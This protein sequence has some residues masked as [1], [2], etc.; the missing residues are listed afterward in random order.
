MSFLD[1]A[2][3]AAMNALIVIGLIIGGVIIT[4]GLY[5]LWTE[6]KIIGYTFH[7]HPILKSDLEKEND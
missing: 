3:Q 2:S 5:S 4:T 1:K 7:G 6:E